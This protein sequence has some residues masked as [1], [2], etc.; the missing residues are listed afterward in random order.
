MQ[1]GMKQIVSVLLMALLAA[2]GGDPAPA[3]PGVG[4]PAAPAA[5][6]GAVVRGEE[7]PGRLLFV[8]GGVVWQWQGREA[9]PLFG[10]GGALQPAFSP[11]GT[12]I[13][14]VARGSSVSELVLADARGA[15]LLRLTAF[16]SGAPINS[17]ERAYASRW[18]LYPAW[19]ADGR[20]VLATVSAGPP[21][22]DPPIEQNLALVRYPI[23]GGRPETLF[24]AA[25]YQAGRSAALPTGELLLVRTAV[26]ADGRQQIAVIA[27][28]G[29]EVAPLPG[30]PEPSYDPAL[31][32]D[33][34]WL[35][36]VSAS[37]DG[38]DIFG[39]PLAGGPAQRLTTMGTARAPRLAPDGSLLAFLAIAPGEGGFDL[40]V[41]DVRRDEAGAIR[42]DRPRRLTT[43]LGLDADSGVSWGP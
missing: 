4:Q 29:A 23:D 32:P 27:A 13:A 19:S 41:A 5:P 8:R 42:L 17:L 30:A 3:S 2:C 39:L 28:P 33:G 21:G 24:E 40:W 9:R 34:S 10:D 35:A 7:L 36:F 15:E 6:A 22:G 12:R 11:D 43:G 38:T 14:Y 16:E 25:G 1:M 26:R 31:A 20:A 37:P 18:A